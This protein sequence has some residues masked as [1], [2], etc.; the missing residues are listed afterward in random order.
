[1]FIFVVLAVAIGIAFARGGKFSR[2]AQINFRLSALIL[3]GFL[4]QVLIFSSPWQDDSQ[5]RA[6]TPYAYLLSLFLLLIAL[7]QN[8]HLKG[9][10]LITL[11]FA[12]N[13]LVIALNGGYMPTTPEARA[14]A[15]QPVLAPGAVRNN[16]IGAGADTRLVFFSDIFAIPKGLPFP[17]V[18]SVGDVLIALGA[19]YLIYKGMRGPDGL[20]DS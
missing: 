13:A 20:Y 8:Q 4:I 3:A 1:V 10:R 15:G 2:L 18:F 7:S 6:L 14:L 17:N 16:S 12:L 19:A 5:T 11:G 9:M